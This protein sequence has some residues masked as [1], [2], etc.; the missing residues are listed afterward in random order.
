[1]A[2][3][4]AARAFECAGAGQL[5]EG[6][7][8]TGLAALDDGLQACEVLP[9]DGGL[10]VRAGAAEQKG[11][12][13]CRRSKLLAILGGRCHRGGD[14]SRQNGDERLQGFATAPSAP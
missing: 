4:E 13:K 14:K 12:C 10:K 9:A 8:L 6:G 5:E 2:A 3:V 7:T 1:V 11:S